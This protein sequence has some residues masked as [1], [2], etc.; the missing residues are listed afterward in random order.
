MWANK[1]FF[2]FEFKGFI[3]LDVTKNFT[4]LLDIVNSCFLSLDSC[5]C[6]LFPLNGL[7]LNQI[8]FL[9][10]ILFCARAMSGVFRVFFHEYIGVG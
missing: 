3:S 6:I 2:F 1:V 10:F 4:N 5:E 9:P 7:K 8:M